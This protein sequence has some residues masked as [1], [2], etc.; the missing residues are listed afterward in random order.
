MSDNL[1]VSD[2]LVTQDGLRDYEQLK[3]MT[4]FVRTGGVV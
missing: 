1:P 4:N 2:L 3:R